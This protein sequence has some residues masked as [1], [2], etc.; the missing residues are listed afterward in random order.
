MQNWKNEA[1]RLSLDGYNARQITEKLKDYQGICDV[2]N[3]YSKVRQY[4]KRERKARGLSRDCTGK[5]Y[6]KAKDNISFKNGVTSFESEQEITVGQEV[7]PELIMVAK[8]LDPKEWEV[9]NFMKNIWQQQTKD[10][11]TINLCQSKLSV[12][13]KKET[14]IT[15]AHIEKYFSTHDFSNIPLNIPSTDYDKSKETLEIDV[16]DLHAGLLAW[17]EETGKSYDLKIMSKRFL[18]CIQDIKDRCKGRQFKKII[19]ANLGDIIHIDNNDQ[20]TTKGTFQQAEGRLEKIVEVTLNTYVQAIL[21]LLDIAPIEFIS[22]KGNHDEVTSF[23]FAFALKKAFSNN[24]NIT[25]DITANPHKARL[26]GNS[27]VGFEHGI[28]SKQRQGDWLVNDCR[29]LFGKCKYAE[30]HCGHLH[31]QTTE[32]KTTGIIVKRLPALCNSSAWEHINGYRAYKAMICFVW[33]DEKLLRE[34]WINYC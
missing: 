27:L 8:G 15:Y 5:V 13:P 24:E 23:M 34:T 6:T 33:H 3:P 32:E 18:E 31:S 2:E 29:E 26:I 19:I 7:T 17:E 30:V 16:A 25:F 1:M 21:M 22:V 9:V 11:T 14:A 4:I 20:R 10:G 12:K 28:E